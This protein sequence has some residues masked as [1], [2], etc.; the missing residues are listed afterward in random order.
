VGVSSLTEQLR[1]LFAPD[2]R[3]GEGETGQGSEAPARRPGHLD[4]EDLEKWKKA[5]LEKLAEDM[6]VDISSAR[7][8]AERAAILAAAEVQAPA[9]SPDD[10]GGGQ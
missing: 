2:S 6:G 5:D 8:N 9:G 4:V 7:T 3:P 1:A 10:T